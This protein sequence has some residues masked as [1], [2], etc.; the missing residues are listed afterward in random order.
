MVRKDL[1]VIGNYGNWEAS[2]GTNA[3]DSEWIVLEQNN[4]D[5]LGSHNTCSSYGCTDLEATNY[6]PC[7][8]V[9]DG[10]CVYPL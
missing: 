1:V 2:A 5:N 7:A 4:W 8:E 10:T 3:E 6:N 9:D